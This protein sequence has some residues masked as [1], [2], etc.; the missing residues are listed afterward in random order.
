MLPV[1]VYPNCVQ[2]LSVCVCLFACLCGRGVGD[3]RRR[4]HSLKLLVAVQLLVAVH[5]LGP[6]DKSRLS[7]LQPLALS[8]G[9]CHRD[10]I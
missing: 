9:L 3:M 8:Q 1:L 5:L 10:D 6:L 2:L 4:Q 7:L